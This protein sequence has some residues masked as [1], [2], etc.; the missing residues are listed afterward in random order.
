[1]L[2]LSANMGILIDFERVS[3]QY[4]AGDGTIHP[5]VQDLSLQ[6]AEGEFVAVVGANGS[7]KSTFSRLIN[8]LL[9][10]T[11][12]TV[13]V[14]GQDTRI[15]GN[16]AAIHA[17]VGMVFQF[18]ED[19]IVSTTVEE[20]VAFGPENL[21]L[22]PAEIRARVD[23]ALREVG[24][25]EMRR[26]PPHLL[27]AGQTQRLA[28]A[29]VLAM[30]PRCI[31][32]DEASTMLDPA[33]RRALMETM[34]RLHQ[35]GTTIVFITHFMDE[36]VQAERVIVLDHNR[37]V[38]D[39]APADIFS[40]PQRLTQLHLDLPAAGG[41]AAA[42][43]IVFPNLPD[44]LFTLPALFRALPVYSGGAQVEA[45][46]LAP[47]QLS[48][49]IVVDHLGHVYL[50]GT[51]LEHRALLDV[52]LQVN[53][54]EAHGLLGKTG[55]G[56]STLLQHLNSL[57]RPQEGSVRVANFNL[58]DLRLDRRQVVQKVGLVFQN[59][60]TQ[61]FET[62]VG[63]EIAYGPRQLKIQEPLAQ[64][65]RW[66]MDQVGLDFAA[67]KDR[68]LYGLSG[69]ERRKVALASTLA[70]RPSILLL[71]EPTAGLDPYSRR[72]LLE[73]LT[74]M[75]ASGMTLVLSSH[76]MEDLAMLAD[77]LTVFSKGRVALQGSAAEVFS[78]GESLQGYGMDLPAAVQ[79]AQALRE[80]GWPIP[81]QILTTEA[82]VQDLLVR[83][84]GRNH[85][86]I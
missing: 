49:L 7:G 61:F 39:G 75:R 13:R 45:A 33:G 32:F 28:L 24:L 82:L 59:P 22:P 85:E 81:Q 16:R 73:K 58:G 14:L 67:F 57:I 44:G 5:A 60:E 40:D 23:E 26:R 83:T 62:F 25:E 29:G 38:L 43:K 4:S 65:V 12:G 53:P 47:E 21:A 20:D 48:P 1:M 68:P 86:R 36:A 50:R 41:I 52:S 46:G 10:P 18:P 77:R 9:V 70:L 76:Q 15:P 6:I 66:A 63:D 3:F 74:Q 51:P 8:G 56:K 19:Q 64:R 54:G 72:E 84:A 80:K 78:Q 17:A 42:L 11:Q 37:L 35:A 27:S 79:V 2:Q 55:S 69:G 31:V 71:D 34:Q 30:R